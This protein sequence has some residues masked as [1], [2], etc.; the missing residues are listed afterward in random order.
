MKIIEDLEHFENDGLILTIGF[1]DGVHAGHRY[2]INQMN[3]I[4]KRKNLKS[5][6]LT[7]WPHPRLVLDEEYK[8]RLLNNIEEKQE[9]L[10]KLPLDYCIQIPFTKE[11]SNYFA[12]D[13]MKQ[14]LKEKLNVK[15]L[16]VG[17]DHRFGKNRE[18]GFDDYCRYGKELDIKVS[19]S[20]PYMEDGYTISS[21]FIRNLL[22]VG[23]VKLASKYLGYNFRIKGTVVEGYKLG[24]KLGYPTANIHLNFGNKSVPNV[25]VYAVKAKL[26]GKVYEGMLYIGNRPTIANGD[27]PSIEV[28]MF[29]FDQEIYGKTL[30]VIFIDRIRKQEKFT[31]TES[32]KKQIGL[33]KE[34]TKKVLLEY[35]I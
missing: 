12:Y 16:L 30:E 24:R 15:Y 3:E 22:N 13:F 35:G 4:A 29:N 17:Y 33:D 5:A 20:E 10:S 8:P 7:F 19:Q 34:Q 18:E 21:S 2:L 25:G 32:L 23:D 31:D 1:F 11:L 27:D 28:N 14:F 6:I 9:L 26:E